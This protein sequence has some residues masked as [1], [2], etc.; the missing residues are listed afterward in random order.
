MMFVLRSVF[1]LGLVFGIAP[2][3]DADPRKEAGVRAANA[4]FQSAA[5]LAARLPEEAEK[6]CRKAPA[7]CLAVA[8]TAVAAKPAASTTP[9]STNVANT[10]VASPKKGK[11]G[12]TRSQQTQTK[13]PQ[14]PSAARG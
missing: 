3:D 14:R 10:N 4:A 6:L 9:A 1:W 8:T 7:E 2:G 12:Q 11:V 5:A 13:P